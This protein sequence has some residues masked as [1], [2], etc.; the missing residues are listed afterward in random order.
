M[1][2]TNCWTSSRL[3]SSTTRYISVILKDNQ[4]RTPF[5]R[6][7]HSRSQTLRA[8][9]QLVAIDDR[10]FTEVIS[11]A[12]DRSTCNYDNMTTIIHCTYKLTQWRLQYRHRW[13]RLRL[14]W[15]TLQ[16]EDCSDHKHITKHA[17]LHF[18]YILRI[19]Y[20]I[21]WPIFVIVR[22]VVSC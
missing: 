2:N 10:H 21:V 12:T 20:N 13:H 19:Q 7:R 3:H 15:S 14:I 4:Q 22:F 8:E 11:I 1:G 9:T 5:Q 17:H 18:L 6:W 16:R